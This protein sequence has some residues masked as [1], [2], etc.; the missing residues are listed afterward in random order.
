MLLV[1]GMTA[2]PIERHDMATSVSAA[3]PNCRWE[4][5][6]S[7]YPSP[8]LDLLMVVLSLG[9]DFSLAYT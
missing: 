6:I 5:T 9:V 1:K 4:F 7:A 3:A 2:I 8:V